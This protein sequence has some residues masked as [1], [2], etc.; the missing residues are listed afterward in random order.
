MLYS[1]IAYTIIL[2][3]TTQH[4]EQSKSEILTT[5]F[6]SFAAGASLASSFFACLGFGDRFRDTM[7]EAMRDASSAMPYRLLVYTT[8][9]I[10]LAVYVRIG[11][12]GFPWNPR[13]QISQWRKKYA[14][15]RRGVVVTKLLYVE[16][17]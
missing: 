16:P 11:M 6:L 3:T 9:S 10:R 17:G 8:T 7:T 15:W 13:T 12:M 2:H 5:N 1:N 4:S 14:S